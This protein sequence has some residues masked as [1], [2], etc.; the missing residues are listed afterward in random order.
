M[1][2]NYSENYDYKEIGEENTQMTENSFNQ[3]DKLQSKINDLDIQLEELRNVRS[4]LSNGSEERNMANEVI[5]QT[6]QLKRRLIKIR[7]EIL[8]SEYYVERMYL[9]LENLNKEIQSDYATITNLV[10][11]VK[12]LAETAKK[13]EEII[14]TIVLPIRD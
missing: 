2:T 3:L 4:E 7:S 10:N 13:A 11:V 12:K 14:K 6:A 1:S 5:K 9:T 8:N